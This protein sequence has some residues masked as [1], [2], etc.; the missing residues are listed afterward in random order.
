M[1]KFAQILALVFALAFGYGLGQ[2]TQDLFATDYPGGG[3]GTHP[4]NLASDVTGELPHGSTSDD[5]ANVHGLGS[6]VNVLGNRDASGEFVQRAA[7]THTA[8]G[9]ADIDQET[10]TF[11]V[12]YSS[13][14]ISVLITSSPDGTSTS[15]IAVGFAD[16]LTTTT[17]R[18]SLVTLD[19]GT[20]NLDNATY[21]LTYISLGN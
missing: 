3:G 12:A 18:S 4:V 20:T 14:P 13:A 11:A 6:N 21:N 2:H 8:A 17:F 5:T 16:A 15:A 19:A 10:K 9:S 7:Y 1:K